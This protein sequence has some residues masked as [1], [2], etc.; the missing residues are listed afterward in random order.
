VVDIKFD[1]LQE[2]AKYVININKKLTIRVNKFC[3]VFMMMNP[4][5]VHD[6]NTGGPESGVV[7]GS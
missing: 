7:R 4:G 1:S 2:T 3:N 6:K 5:I